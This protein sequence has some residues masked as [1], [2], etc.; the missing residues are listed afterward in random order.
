M[1]S[2]SNWLIVAGVWLAFASGVRADELV[3]R[4]GDRL[5]GRIVHLTGGKL[6]FDS[7]LLGQVEV[8]ADALQNLVSTEPIEIHT[9][10]GSVFTDR[11]VMGES[12]ELRTQGSSP[13]GA[14]QVRGGVRGRANR[15][16]GHRCRNHDRA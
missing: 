14:H 5:S 8:A 2:S 16:L 11:A 10:D 7:D 3:F 9:V 13:I 4:N 15:E 1:I 6:A 12:G